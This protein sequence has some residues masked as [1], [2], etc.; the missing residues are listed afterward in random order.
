[1]IEPHLEVDVKQL[2]LSDFRY[3]HFSASHHQPILTL[4]VVP[5]ILD[6]EVPAIVAARV[7]D[8]V[9]QELMPLGHLVGG[10]SGR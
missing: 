9:G 10:G 2:L 1:M 7:F 6:F 4:R 5:R 3:L 8:W